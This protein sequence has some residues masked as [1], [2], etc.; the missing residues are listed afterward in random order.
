MTVTRAIIQL[1]KK[2]EEKKFRNGPNTREIANGS[3][4]GRAWHRVVII[5]LSL[6]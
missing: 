3:R 2:G 4:Q 5:D 1:E 6:V